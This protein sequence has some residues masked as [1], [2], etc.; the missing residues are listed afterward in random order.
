[1]NA[2]LVRHSV[3]FWSP[4][5]QT[6]WVSTSVSV[7]KIVQYRDPLRTNPSLPSSALVDLPTIVSDAATGGLFCLGGASIFRRLRLRSAK[8]NR[9]RSLQGVSVISPDQQNDEKQLLAISNLLTTLAFSDG[10]TL[11]TNPITFITW[12]SEIIECPLPEPVDS[13][14]KN[15][16]LSRDGR[17]WTMQTSRLEW[18]S[19]G[20]YECPIVV[21]LQSGHRTA[22]LVLSPGLSVTLIGASGSRAL[23]ALLTAIRLSPWATKVAIERNRSGASIT[24]LE[25][26]STSTPAVLTDDSTQQ[27]DVTIV[28]DGKGVTLHPHGRSFRP[29]AM[30]EDKTGRVPTPRRGTLSSFGAVQIQGDLEVKLL[31]PL[32]RIEG[33]P[34]SIVPKRARRATELVAY[35][36]IHHP[37]PVSSDR[38]R[39]RVLGTPDADAAAKTLFNTIGAARRAMG[40]DGDGRPYL[41]NASR[42]GHYT[43]SSLVTTDVT[44]ALSLVRS[45]KASGSSDEKLALFQAAFD[46][47]LGEPLAGALNGYSWWTSEGHEGKLMASL[48]DAASEAVDLA[49][50]Q[51]SLDL[52]WWII[53]K[54]GRIDPY[55]EQISR[56]AMATA[57]AS[58]DMSSLKREWN[59][60]RRRVTEL[61]PDGFP[62]PQ[63]A[64]LFNRLLRT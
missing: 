42:H 63:T 36:A 15:W 54:A 46:L 41:P 12:D 14:P 27:S 24:W 20:S 25:G 52:A 38:L 44:C 60:C 56:A 34:E 29:D 40:L 45:A 4:K 57:A 48:V 26:N 8:R 16:E 58:G 21:P 43:I 62:S 2:P 47:V 18:D 37:D 35:L 1:M 19:L 6:F 64:R 10:D 59:E 17:S 31:A 23:E 53:D 9:W 5:T 13:A 32:P 49:T 7:S 22:A 11:P 51:G 28:V 39:T 61:D 33:L 3:R 50:A 30:S 55:S